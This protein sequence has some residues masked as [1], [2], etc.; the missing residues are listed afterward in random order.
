MRPSTKGTA[1]CTNGHFPVF[2]QNTS[3][4][5]NGDQ[6]HICREENLTSCDEEGTARSLRQISG[7]EHRIPSSHVTIILYS[8]LQNGH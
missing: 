7:E 1:V 5:A 3:T 2:S 4:K 6:G 8:K